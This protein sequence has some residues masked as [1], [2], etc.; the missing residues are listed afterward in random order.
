[1]NV[2]SAS[3]TSGR[4]RR[5]YLPATTAVPSGEE[6]HHRRRGH[7]LP[8]RAG[9]PSDP[10][11]EIPGLDGYQ[12]AGSQRRNRLVQGVAV[13]AADVD[14]DPHRPP[15]GLDPIH[16]EPGV[17]P[18]PAGPPV[19]SSGFDR[20]LPLTDAGNPHRLPDT[21]RPSHYALRLEPDLERAVFRGTVD[22][23]VTVAAPCTELVCN[24]VDLEI[25]A[26]TLTDPDGVARELAATL[27]PELERVSFGDGSAIQPGDLVL[28]VEFSGVLNDKLTGFYRS[29]F[30]DDTGSEHTLATTQFEATHA[31]QAF[32]CWDEPASKATFGVTL[33]VDADHLA[34][35][36]A[37][38]VAEE[39]VGDGRR[40]VTFADTMKM[41]TYL[42]ALVVGTLEATAPVDVDGVDVRVV[43]RPGQIHLTHHAVEVATAALRWFSD[44]YGIPYPGDKLDLVAVPD[45]AF[46]AMENLGC[47]TFREALLLVDPESATKGELQRITDVIN[48]E[49]AHMWFGDLVTMKWWNGIWLNEA[50]ATFME[51]AATDAFRPE[52]SRW[53]SFARERSGAFDVDSLRT[54]RPIEFPVVSP[55]DAE[56]MFDVLT[57]EKGAAVVRMLEQYLGE[58]P[59]RDGIR[60]YLDTYRYANTET[61][62]LWDSIETATDQPA[63][64]IMDS[65]IYQGGH[66]VVTATVSEDRTRVRLSQAPSCYTTP[67][68][69]ERSA[70]PDGTAIWMVPVT[71]RATAV[72]GGTIHDHALLEGES[73]EITLESAIE[74]DSL[75]VNESATG[76]FRVGYGSDQARRIAATAGSRRS[77]AER[78]AFLDDTWTQVVRGD[79]DA[80]TY[81]DLLECFADED[82]TVVW[83]R[84]VGALGSLDRLVDDET[85]PILAGRFRSLLR[86]VFDRVGPDPRI[87]DDDLTL[88]RRGLL[89][90]A[91]GTVGADPAILDRAT[92]LH[93]RYLVDRAS[94]DPAL[95]A[96]ALNVV[97]THADESTYDRLT[98]RFRTAE[99][100]QE[101]LRY[102]YALTVPDDPA[103]IARTR[104]LTLTDSVRTQN[105]P[106][107]LG[108]AF[109]HR[110]A[111]PAT[112]RFI[113]DRWIDITER[114]PSN[115]L[116]RMLDGMRSISDPDTADDISAFFDR[117]PLP[118][119]AQM[120][121]QHLERMSVTV[122]LTRR[123][124]PRLH[125]ALLPR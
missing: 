100:P 22:I 7:L 3:R 84:I 117:H 37:A 15:V 61:T 43:H 74:P 21:A 96:G 54:T 93:A 2:R 110:A 49:I 94:V 41:S 36:N 69:P 48:H 1:M 45:F 25:S 106:Y 91:L 111:G 86:P 115:S 63:R 75:V 31:R 57:Y 12:A 102:L 42:V 124:R 71:L 53:D 29:T 10:T 62:D 99:G 119:A 58:I 60:R 72:D 98:Q 89:L 113:E 109:A 33:V 32:P 5:G 46:G 52:W 47:V 64:R 88:E 118:Q 11:V 123:E 44:Y 80:V 23:D 65:W 116:G 40:Q 38:V 27:D 66:P 114:F 35:S 55:D 24:A 16:P 97:A 104:D 76:F 112:W 19:R 101:L 8:A 79:L 108:Q 30:T 120:L 95:L 34:L 4:A 51:V 6:M 28:S 17:E 87:D 78:H 121:A 105:A 39:A 70:S 67:E 18:R 90:A 77:V 68:D 50:F 85:R 13:G 59:F 26:A 9:D 107:V 122:E 92:D 83:H 82:E 81:L 56:G 73:T 14:E 125:A 20:R 103:L